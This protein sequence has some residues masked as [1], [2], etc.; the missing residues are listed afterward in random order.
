MLKNYLKIAWRNILKSKGYSALNILGLA[1]GM[2]VALI[3]GL[4][5]LY[6]FSYDKFLPNNKQLYRV[7]RN[8]NSNGDTLTFASTS[9]KLAQTLRSQVPEIEYV[10]EADWMGSH[11]LVVGTTKLYMNGGQVGTDFLMMFQFPFVQGN[12]N[13]VFTDPYSIVLTASTAKALFGTEDAINKTLRFD[14]K[15]ELKVT[16]VLKDLPAASS[17]QFKFLVPFTYLLQTAGVTDP[18]GSYSSNGWQQF[19]QLKPGVS[20]A[21]VAPKI[22]NI[23]HTEKESNNA[24]KSFVILQPL[25]NWHLY[26]NY[27]N[28]KETGGFLDYVRMFSVIGLLVL[29]IACIN[30]INLT[31][32]GSQ[33]RAKEVGIRK[34][35]GSKRKEL[36]FQFLMESFLLTAIALLFA[37]AMVQLALPFFNSLAGTSISIPFSSIFFWAGML[38]FLIATA[39]LAGSRPAFYLSSFSPVKVLKGTMQLG[40]L[41]TLPRKVL[42]VL[43]FSCSVALIISTVI[44]YQQIEHA[45]NRPSGYNVNRLMVTD[46]SDELS[47]N[48]TALKDELIANGVVSDVAT[49]TSNATDISWHSD[50]DNWPGKNAGET[51]EMGMIGVTK[52]YFATL[53]MSIK[54]GSDFSGE[55]DTTS[56]L[57]NEAAVKRLRLKDPVNKM[58]TVQGRQALI[59]GVVKD[60]LM[61]SPFGAAD[62]TMFFCNDGPAGVLLY[63]LSPSIPTQDAIAKLTTIFNKYNAAYPYKYQFADDSYAAKF[64][65]EVLIGRLAGIFTGLAIFISC[66]GLFGLS[67]YTAKQKTKEIGVRKVLGASIPQVWLM[68]SKDFILLVVISCLIASPIAMYFLQHWL[69]QYQYRINIGAG[70][71]I[72]SAMMAIFITVVTVSFQAI[73]AAVLNPV[74]SLRSE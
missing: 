31:T 44:I 21:Q 33:K 35:I 20:Y 62:P 71:F 26:G 40:R 37:L 49:A 46:M 72:V 67:A 14:N 22:R 5:V 57:F 8:F 70:V 2:A 65:V 68:L 48:Y 24:M 42:V 45:R 1:T 47:H 69:Q 51:V 55:H 23:E 30:F 63:R 29:L 15:N 50:I 66:L 6:Q 53:G 27:V 25:L 61:V 43:Q 9:L 7:Q 38:A 10:T 11:G 56:V 18:Y 4:W 52:D 32:A 54:E 74:K 12:A 58:I 59:K 39:I 17:F 73:K 19:V 41:A 60:A 3:I 28:G 13:T 64:N 36:I 16:G 34:A